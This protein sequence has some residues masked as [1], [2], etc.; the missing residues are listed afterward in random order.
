MTELPKNNEDFTNEQRATAA[1]AALERVDKY[2]PLHTQEG[3]DPDSIAD[4]VA[5]LLHLARRNQIEPDYVIETA[6]I[7]FQAEVEEEAQVEN[8]E[9]PTP[10][11]EKYAKS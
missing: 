1:L 10:E 8:P 7:N 11:R 4:L 9:E 5:D 3:I 6:K 2:Q